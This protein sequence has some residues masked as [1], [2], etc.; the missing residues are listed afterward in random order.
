MFSNKSEG[1]FWSKLTGASK[2]SKEMI[3]AKKRAYL[4]EAKQDATHQ[5]PEDP[6]YSLCCPISK[7][8]MTDPVIT[9]HGK[10]YDKAH[11]LREL[12]LRERDPE[13]RLPLTKNDIYLFPE[14][15]EP[16]AVFSE[17][18]RKYFER[19]ATMLEIAFEIAHN[20][21]I[22]PAPLEFICPISKQIMAVPVITA[23]GKIY[24][25]DALQQYMKEHAGV[26]E[27]G[28]PLTP[29]DYQPFPAFREQ[30]N[31]YLFKQ[32]ALRKGLNL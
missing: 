28:L 17:R 2:S 31:V 11:I 13:T 32:D 16:L 8:L 12:T 18:Q 14:L 20:D 10:V 9:I 19:K 15:K 3:E 21:Q 23:Q 5:H 6:P 7:S 4:V 25:R 27:T 22:E 30:I 26:D 24:D 1:G 29:D